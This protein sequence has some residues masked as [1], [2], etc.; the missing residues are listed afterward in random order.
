VKKNTHQSNLSSQNINQ[1]KQ[2]LSESTKIFN[3]TYNDIKII[4]DLLYKDFENQ[5]WRRLLI[6]STYSH[7]ESIC[8]HL[9]LLAYLKDRI[10]PKQ[11]SRAEKAILLEESYLLTDSGKVKTRLSFQEA[12]KNLR[13]AFKTVARVYN[14]NFKLDINNKGWEAYQKGLKIRNQIAHPKTASDITI[15]DEEIKIVGDAFHW[16]WENFK[17][18][19]NKIFKQLYQGGNHGNL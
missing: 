19:T 7:I 6:R 5:C 14:I 18:L 13:F 17:R 11:L 1:L 10:G 4:R 8:F 16:F 2:I 3:A 9:K 12:T 15:L